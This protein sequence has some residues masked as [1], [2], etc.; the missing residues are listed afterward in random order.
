MIIGENRPAVIENIKAAVANGDFYK[1][2]ETNDPVLSPAEA[3]SIT[4]R[5]LATRKTAA[6]KF[7]SFVARQIA[8]IGTSLLNKDT[9]IIGDVD[10]AVLKNGAVITSNHFSPIENT[11]IRH[12]I[13]KKGLRRLNIVSQVTNFAMPGIIG[14]LMNYADTIPLS[15]DMRY[16]SKNFI[17]VLK[18]LV[19]KKE[20]VLIYPEQEMWFNYRKPRPLKRGAYHFAAKLNR[21]IVSCFVEMVERPEM[22]TPEFHKVQYCLHILGVIYPDSSKSIKEN[23]EKMCK[24]DYALKKD[25]YERAYGKPLDYSFEISDIAGW[26]PNE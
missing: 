1:K 6:F 21:P 20:V 3:K 26:Q 11:V 25:A 9:E 12:Y 19:N 5:Y 24:A 22:E 16:L 15:E 13:R 8:N 23:S 4:D 2:V 14:F 10:A 18:E 7:K 17:D